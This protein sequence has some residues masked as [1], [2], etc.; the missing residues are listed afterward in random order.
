MLAGLFSASLVSAQQPKAF[1]SVQTSAAVSVIP[2]PSGP[3]G[4]GRIG[5]HWIDTSRPDK[6]DPK[7]KRD[8]MVYFWYP[9]AKSVGA[10]GQYLPG[11]AQMDAVPA[12][13]EFM[14]Q[15]FGNAWAAIVSGKISSHV[16]ERAPIASSP[17]AFPLV[18]FSHGLGGSGFQYTQLIEDLV[19]HG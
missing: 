3:L 11:A 18:T 10:K 16:I 13:H 17:T 9:T 8:M 2:Y 6:Y 5:F 1:S 4:I 12:V 7:R 14:S 19:S 15:Q